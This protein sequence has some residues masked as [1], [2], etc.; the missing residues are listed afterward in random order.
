MP[1]Q[2]CQPL[3]LLQY[4]LNPAVNRS[5]IAS[6]VSKA[7]FESGPRSASNHRSTGSSSGEHAGNKSGSVPSGQATPRWCGC[8]PVHRQDDLLLR[9]RSPQLIEEYREAVPI[10]ARHV[11][12]EARAG[13]ELHRRVQP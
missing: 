4:G 10:E 5:A 2:A 3:R 7:S 9:V 6:T 11:Q 1:R 13:G 8:R 12:A